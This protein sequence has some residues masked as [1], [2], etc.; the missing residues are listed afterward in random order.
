MS[1]RAVRLASAVLATLGAAITAY[2]LYVRQSGGALVCSTGGCDTVQGSAYAEV[3]GVPVAALGLVG[4]LGLLLAAAARGEWA[5]LS[6]V[7]LAFTAF[8]FG[9]YLLYIQLAVIDAICEWCLATDV[10]TTVI[11]ALALLRLR[12]GDARGRLA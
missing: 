6:Q 5:R 1:E 11:I 9:V 10:L 2:L 8:A 12:L 7:T 3:L 4:F